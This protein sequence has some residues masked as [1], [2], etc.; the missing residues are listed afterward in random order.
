MYSKK[1]N[2]VSIDSNL[3]NA[4]SIYNYKGGWESKDSVVKEFKK[5]F[6]EEALAKLY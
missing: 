2:K 1:L 4:V 6:K 5:A 3:Q